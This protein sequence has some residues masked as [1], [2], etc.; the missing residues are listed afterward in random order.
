MHR[1][2][3]IR[4]AAPSPT[5]RRPTLA[6]AT[7]AAVASFA[8]T[9]MVPAAPP[10]ATGRVEVGTVDV[11]TFSPAEHRVAVD[12]ETAD[13]RR[14]FEDLGEAARRW[15]HHAVT[16]SNPYFEG[17]APGEAGIER[18][19]DY[20]TF[21]FERIGLEPAF[22]GS[23]RQ[24]FAV[25]GG[26]VLEW[27][28]V[29]VDGTALE[30][31]EESVELANTGL[32]EVEGDLAF[33]GYGIVDGPDGFD[34][35][36][37]AGDLAGKV[38]MVFRY[39][40]LDAEGRSRWSERRY[41]RHASLAAKFKAI[42]SRGAAGVL[43]VNPPGVAVGA[44]GMERP[45]RGGLGDPLSIP[46]VQISPKAA[47]RMLASLAAGRGEPRSLLD[48]RRLADEGGAMPTAA[49]P[50]RVR[51]AV[52]RVVSETSNVAGILPGAGELASEWVV[53]G[54]H[55]DHLGRLESG[56]IDAIYPGADDNA[57]GTAAVLVLAEQFER[58]AA[59]SDA[60][61]GDRRSILFIAFS[62]EEQGLHGS[63][64]FVR[65]PIMPADRVN[66]MVNLD[67]MGR[68]RSDELLVA[69]VG[70]AEGLLD[71]LRPHFDASGLLVR[72]DPSGRGPSD[73]SS[74]HGAGIPAIFLFTG[75]HDSY[76]E[77]EDEW[78]TLDPAGAAKVLRLAEAIVA[79]LATGP[80]LRFTDAA[81]RPAA[82]GPRPGYAAVRLGVMPGLS[83]GEEGGLKVE[84]VSAG[85]S[86][87]EA[88]ILA[89][90]VLVSWNGSILHGAGDLVAR[91]REHQPGD[92][93]IIVLRRDGEEREV[94]VVLQAAAPRPGPE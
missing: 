19:A 58:A 4:P 80:A 27:A 50:P 92:A 42:E 83:E 73:H 88:G 77:P 69:G 78:H 22:D 18:A 30:P 34:S 61:G 79:E 65:H 40:P 70:T 46:V 10:P 41:S 52:E 91:L 24:I 90:D 60:A 17:R 93:V 37:E 43:L 53:V 25:P 15:Q 9:T 68:L 62:A 54:G 67:M 55:Y 1:T 28:A 32:G 57:S 94:E 71:R 49:A 59:A 8:A 66:A 48:W 74:F 85:T 14:L 86:A 87:A 47:E 11:Y 13:L 26:P 63:R 6:A 5:F 31:G 72:A 33:A 38:V 12:A 3:S 35:F 44:T 64:H 39:E 56:G 16:L 29:S 21:W 2:A 45:P 82:T 36:A 76:H 84:A 7:A 51:I 89:G 23:Y 75:V 20:L 81:P